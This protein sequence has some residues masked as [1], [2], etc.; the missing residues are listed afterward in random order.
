MSF[1]GTNAHHHIL[2]NIWPKWTMLWWVKYAGIWKHSENARPEKPVKLLD[3]WRTWWSGTMDKWH[4]TLLRRRYIWHYAHYRRCF[5]I[6]LVRLE[7]K[8]CLLSIIGGC[9]KNTMGCWSNLF[10]III[11]KSTNTNATKSYVNCSTS[12]QTRITRCIHSNDL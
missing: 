3:I 7:P 5:K 12:F 10:A 9:L 4:T 11:R 6:Q 1:L 8:I 2:P